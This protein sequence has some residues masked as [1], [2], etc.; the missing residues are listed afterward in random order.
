MAEL[1]LRARL[2]NRAVSQSLIMY[3]LHT[4]F[5]FDCE[6]K[7]LL[8]TKLIDSQNYD[9]FQVFCFCFCGYEIIYYYLFEN[10]Q[11]LCLKYELQSSLFL[12]VIMSKVSEIAAKAKES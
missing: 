9:N 8:D 10:E 1:A 11:C 4:K 7:F 5:K 12:V 6:V 2:I 3:E